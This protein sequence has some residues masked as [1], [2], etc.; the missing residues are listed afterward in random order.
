MARTLGIHSTMVFREEMQK[1][2]LTALALKG[3]FTDIVFQGGTALRIFHG[4]PR[5]SEDIDLVLDQS[6]MKHRKGVESQTEVPTDRFPNILI[7]ALPGIKQSVRDNFPFI[8]EVEIR[9][10]KKDRYL[11]RHI[12][13]T[14]SDNPEQNL[15]VHIE[16]AAIPSYRNQPRILNFPPVNAAVRVE[17]E[18]EILADKVCAIALRPYLKGRD[19]WDIHF[20]VH[21]H[22]VTIDWDLVLRKVKDYLKEELKSVHDDKYREALTQGLE[23]ASDRIGEKGISTLRNEMERFLPPRVHESYRSSF[24]TILQ[25]VNDIITNYSADPGA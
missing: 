5:F 22:H 20:L 12:L 1:V 6:S 7:H 14:R 23:K 11:Q 2:V 15:R 17:N 3:C 21:D 25:T 8:T 4:N 10:Q 18:D 9:T 19:L 13:L 16:L 24:N